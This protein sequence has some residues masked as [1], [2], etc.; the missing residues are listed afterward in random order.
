VTCV[1]VRGLT[2]LVQWVGDMCDSEGCDRFGTVGG[3][4]RSRNVSE[5][6]KIF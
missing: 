2:G 6:R 3:A 5:S 4:D 1:T